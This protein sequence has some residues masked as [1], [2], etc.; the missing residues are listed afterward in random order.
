MLQSKL[1]T[2]RPVAQSDLATLEAWANDASFH[3]PFNTFGLRRAGSFELRFAEHG[4]LG[5]QDGL[6]LV[7]APDKTPA[8]L[9]SYRLIGYGPSNGSRVYNIGISL[10]PEQRGRG[11]GSDA[12][13]RLADYLFAT[14]PIMRV[15]ATTDID[16]VP[17]QGALV[18]AGFT[19][20]GVLRKAQWR[21]GAWHDMV[22]Y[23]R[24]RGE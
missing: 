1:V 18:K 22:I 13:R 2:L 5:E 11:Y 4:L 12:Q 8:G 19:R 10:A 21:D 3:G 20:E 6:L 16:N 17:E 15:E 24:L 9:V 14:Y 23:S 7:I